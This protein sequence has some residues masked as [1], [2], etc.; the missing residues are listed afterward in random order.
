MGM[1]ATHCAV[2]SGKSLS[3]GRTVPS[4]ALIPWMTLAAAAGAGGIQAVH[5]A[6]SAADATADSGTLAEVVVT[7]TRRAENAQD[8][9]ESI[10]VLSGDALQVLGDTGD[11]FRQLAFR[12]PS[13]QVESSNGR[14]F[15]RIYIRGYGNSDYHDFASQPVGLVYDDIVQENAA[16]KGFP[17]FDQADIEVLRGPQGTLFGRNSPAGV[18]K[19]ESAKPVLGETSGFVSLSDGT[20][21]SGVFQ[22]VANLPVNDQIAFR[23]SIQGQHRDNWVNDP[24]TDSQL[25]GFNDWAGRLQLLFKPSDEF[26]V[27]FNVH[28]RDLTGSSSLF[29]ANIIDAGSHDL[30]PGFNPANIDTDGPNT[31]ALT[32]VGANLHLTWEL[33]AL[34]VQSISG[35]E[36]VRKYFSLGDIDGGCGAAFSPNTSCNAVFPSG[37]GPGFIPFTVETSAQL[38]HHYQLTQEFRVVSKSEGPL[39][40]QAGVFLFYE[41]ITAADDDYCGPGECTSVTAPPFFQLQDTTVSTQKNDAE[42][43][44]GSLDYTPVDVF[45]ASAGVRV[46]SDHKTFNAFYVDFIQPTNNEPTPPYSA[47]ESAHNVS[48][49]VSGTYRLAPD[50]SVYARIATGFR[51]PSFGE[52]TPGLGIQTVPSEKNIS[53]ETGVKADLFEHRA[54]VA[55]D[56]FYFHVTDQQ[57]T[58]VGGTQDVTQLITAKDVVGYGSELDF[59]AHPVSNLSFNASASLNIT[60]IEDPN[61]TVVVGGSV[62]P[63]DILNPYKTVPGAFGPVYYANV[64]GNPLP[65]AAKWIADVSARYDIPL[66]TG[67]KLYAYTDWSYRSGFDYFLYA[68]KEYD[69]PALTQAGLRLGYTWAEGKYDAAVYCRN[70]TNQVRAI[71]AIDFDNLTGVVNDPRI[72]GAQIRAKF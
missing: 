37:S 38:N 51:A 15:P 49:D 5:A 40:G 33:P 36:S 55:L 7:A 17:I 23:A 25:G 13:L 43:I 58:I 53:Y 71:Y 18:V 64:N 72:F 29:R 2:Q 45:T 60:R 57:L 44:F 19:L 54:R 8:V 3:G 56:G 66:P 69:G 31:S 20:Y 22:G 63:G 50:L 21:N 35:Y 12:V 59:E 46:T 65:E 47:G 16:L 39:K 10:S 1:K 62:P 11:D 68:A 30:V 70:C 28:A 14:A 4:M 48:W 41:N 26:S 32:T 9:P 24:I 67:G 27:L 52:P 61:L 34:T 42:A 6:D